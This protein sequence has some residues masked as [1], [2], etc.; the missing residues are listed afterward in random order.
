MPL[1]E[2]VSGRT[3]VVGA[4]KAAASMAEVIEKNW[5]H[6]PLEG[7]VITRYAHGL[8]LE[9]IEVVEAGHPVPDEAGQKAAEKIL[10]QVSDLTEDDLV[11]VL[12]SG[13][14]SSLLALPA[15]GVS[16]ESKKAVNKALL[17]S[18]ADISEMNTVR[19]KL[20]SIKGG[21]LA[22]SAYPAKVVTYMI[23]DVPGDDPSVIA[24]GPTVPDLTTVADA[25]AILKK[26]QID[27]PADVAVH[28]ETEAAEPPSKD[29]PAFQS[30]DAHMMTIPQDILQETAIYARSL[31][32]TPVVLGDQLEGEAK[33]VAKVH[34]AIVRQENDYDQPLPKPCVILSGGETT[35]TVRSTETPGRGGRNAEFLLALADALGPMENVF[36]LAADTDGIDGTED[37]AGALLNPG[38]YEK[39]E[40]EG[41]SIREYL[42]RHDAYSFFEKLGYL[43]KTGPTRTN[44]N[45]F[46]AI[47]IL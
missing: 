33:D 4:G 9:K 25:K 11:I 26:Y 27:I 22:V 42:E 2:P 35:V 15:D 37:N 29:H 28:L 31:G 38:L 47:L 12:I 45:D 20:S 41:L 18:G 32:I 21:R 34:A 6:G 46:R 1:P 19:K 10:A 44:V 7:V 39:A 5:A 3:I 13:G 36:A 8:P 16:L 43:V 30:S 24:S 17:A 14:G 23:S 40:E